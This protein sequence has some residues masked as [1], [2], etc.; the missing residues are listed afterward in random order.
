[1]QKLEVGELKERHRL[2]QMCRAHYSRIRAEQ[3]NLMYFEWYQRR[4]VSSEFERE[5][6]EWEP[7]E[8]ETD[9][10][11]NE[12]EDDMTFKISQQRLLEMLAIEEECNCDISAGVDYG[13]HLGDYIASVVNV[14]PPLLNGEKLMSL[15]KEELGNRLTQME[16]EE[17]A[18]AV[19]AGVR[20][21]VEGQQSA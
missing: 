8:S 15:L 10:W 2:Q 16:L 1:V 9:Q 21:R 18:A 4:T 19:Q 3:D 17:L 13:I 14:S 5:T 12:Q 7:E 20:A 11:Q 6:I